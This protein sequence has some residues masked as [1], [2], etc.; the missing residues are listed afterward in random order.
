LRS[1]DDFGM[2]DNKK[3]MAKASRNKRQRAERS[4]TTKKISEQKVLGANGRM[5]WLHP[6]ALFDEGAHTAVYPY[7]QLK[8]ILR[9]DDV[10]DAVLDE[11]CF[12]EELAGRA[13]VDPFYELIWTLNGCAGV[14]TSHV[15][16][17]PPGYPPP[18]TWAKAYVASAIILLSRNSND[19]QNAAGVQA[20]TAEL[21]RTIA[22]SPLVEGQNPTGWYVSVGP[23]NVIFTN[24]MS[25]TT[26]ADTSVTSDRRGFGCQ[27]II[28]GAANSRLNASARWSRAAAFVG[29]TLKQ[30]QHS[31]G[32]IPAPAHQHIRY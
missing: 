1:K 2:I 19:H 25:K 15:A 6:R 26:F 5:E 29:D 17:T 20:A 24:E 21:L 14:F 9:L 22:S 13:V 18:Y 27:L 30:V 4:Q 8:E 3:R 7:A 11:T 12:L 32:A 31:S 16:V 23:V 28:G 10:R